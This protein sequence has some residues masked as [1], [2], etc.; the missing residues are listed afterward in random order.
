MKIYHLSHTDLDGYCCQLLTKEI[1]NNIEFLNANYGEEVGIRLEYIIKNIKESSTKTKILITDL[2]LTLEE[3]EFLHKEVEN[4]NSSGKEVKLQLLDH[5]ATGL[6][7]AENFNWY[8]LDVTKSATLITY[9]YL[10]ENYAAKNLTKY[11]QLVEAVNAV[12]LWLQKHELFEFGK[13]CMRLVDE[14]KEINRNLFPSENAEYKHYVIKTAA[15]YIGKEEAHIKLDDNLYKIKK[16]FFRKDKNDTLDNMVTAYI[17]SLLNTK[18]DEMTIYY[19]NNK[20]I[21]TYSIGNTSIIGNEFL[22]QNPD[23]SFFMNVSARGSFSLR[24]NNKMD[25]SKMAEELAGGGGHPNA[26]GGRIKG[27]KEQFIYSELKSNIE[28]LLKEK[29]NETK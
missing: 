13:V 12:D 3:A 17:V 6:D 28:E 27:F 23:Y 10:I 20:G 29:E 5:H 24:A 22:T 11:L 26:S 18:K 14:A 21:L 16:S 25:V 19:K 1:F 2:N 15:D 8:H 7:S 9:K 4:L